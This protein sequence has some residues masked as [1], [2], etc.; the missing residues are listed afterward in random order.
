MGGVRRALRLLR[1][2]NVALAAGFFL[3]LILGP[4]I[5]RLFVPL[6][7][8]LL[9]LVIA[10]TASEVSLRA[11]R[12]GRQVLA[13][14]GLAVLSSY[15]IDSGAILLLA[16]LLVPEPELYTGF[17]LVAAA[18][19][20]ASALGFC[21]AVR[22]NVTLSLIG[23]IG[24]YVVAPFIGPLIAIL[25]AGQGLIRPEQLFT[26]LVQLILIPFALSR[27]LR[28]R[29]VLPYTRRWRDVVLGWGYG[30]VLL[31]VVGANRNTFFREPALV[32][33][34]ALVS[35]LTTFGLGALLEWVMGRLHVAANTRASLLLLSTLKNSGFAAAVAL[36][37]VSLRASLPGAIVTIVEAIFLIFLGLRVERQTSCPPD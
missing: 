12:H 20:A 26:S 28:L 9:G 33:L 24:A 11:F 7:L 31:T 2:R 30:I 22:G 14:T 13:G 36:T 4:E 37:L 15:V 6:A 16:R 5:A 29:Q 10:V 34:I 25:F 23:T 3:G 1:N 19:P 32:G 8:P 18:P 21:L 17:V 27:V 35:V